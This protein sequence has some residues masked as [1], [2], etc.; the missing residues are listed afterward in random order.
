MSYTVY[1][2]AIDD[3][4][5]RMFVM[6]GFP[7]VFHLLRNVSLICFYLFPLFFMQSHLPD[8]HLDEEG[9]GYIY[10]NVRSRPGGS[11]ARPCHR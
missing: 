9:H 10:Y 8:V 6:A 7:Q 5:V 3:E 11:S 1:G 4:A 2:I